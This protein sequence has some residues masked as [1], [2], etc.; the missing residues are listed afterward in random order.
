MAELGLETGFPWCQ[1]LCSA[2]PCVGW[3]KSALMVGHSWIGPKL[4][5][6]WVGHTDQNTG[7]PEKCWACVRP[8]LE[9]PGMLVVTG[10]CVGSNPS[11]NNWII[12][13]WFILALS[14]V[15][16]Y[17]NCRNKQGILE[18][19]RGSIFCCP[20]IHELL[21]QIVSILGIPALFLLDQG[22]FSYGEGFLKVL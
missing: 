13:N 6:M 22:T 18:L 8:L 1:N 14:I 2:I 5:F 20:W 17:V 9:L 11:S 4:Y 16:H 12:M 19:G 21:F 7:A 10:V 3:V 15:F